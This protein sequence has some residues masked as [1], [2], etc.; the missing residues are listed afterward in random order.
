MSQQNHEHG[1][2][3]ERLLLAETE[4]LIKS[5]RHLPGHHRDERQEAER[6]AAGA[7]RRRAQLRKAHLA[8][9]KQD[10]RTPIEDQS[11]AWLAP[12]HQEDLQQKE[13]AGHEQCKP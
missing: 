3:H 9:Q 5:Q 11:T 6:E 8:P 1:V 13:Q 4:Y 2:E 12:D 10:A 7:I